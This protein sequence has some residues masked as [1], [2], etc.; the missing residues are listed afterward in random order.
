MEDVFTASAAPDVM[1]E[2]EEEEVV[3]VAAQVSV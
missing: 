1:E 2:G 3:V